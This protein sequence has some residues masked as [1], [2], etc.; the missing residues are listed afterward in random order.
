MTSARR[1]YAL[2]LAIGAAGAAATVLAVV[3]AV[4]TVELDSRSPGALL[5]ACR[6]F[7][8]AGLG[9]AAV[10]VLAV[11]VVGVLVLSLWIRSL[12]RQLWGTRRHLSR[13]AL[14][15][16]AA[17]AGTP[18]VVFASARGDAFC[19]G[20]LRPRIYI[21]TGALALLSRRELEAVLAHERHHRDRRDPLRLLLIRSLA[22]ALF[23]MPALRRLGERYAALAELAAD[24][25]AIRGGGAGTLTSALLS[26]GGG[27][28][29]HAV[30][31]ISPERADH[32]LG[33]T[34]PRWELPLSLFAGVLLTVTGIA[35]L[36][37]IAASAAA[38]TTVHLA[39]LLAG[40]CMIL[41]LLVPVAGAVRL[42]RRVAAGAATASAGCRLRRA[43][44]SR[45]L[46][47]PVL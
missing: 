14:V 9:W 12:A 36:G 13:L 40:S 38:G 25:A 44:R 1:L 43:R 26:F 24:E 8:P 21:S 47:C 41:M 16:R 17:V 3:A 34:E 35:A 45:V 37:A 11:L 46:R 19:A 33:A 31:G 22:D 32:I 27:P 20:C 28:G 6:Q 10:L 23:F 5:G 29:A 18:V 2:A 39:M 30:V 4:S 7:L 15:E 42:L